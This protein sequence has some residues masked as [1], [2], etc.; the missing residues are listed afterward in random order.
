MKRVVAILFVCLAL[1]SCARPTP[2]KASCSSL[3]IQISS[4]PGVPEAALNSFQKRL[5]LLF[6]DVAKIQPGSACHLSVAI[7]TAA[8]GVLVS[9]PDPLHFNLPRE[10]AGRALL[11]AQLKRGDETLWSSSTEMVFAVD[12]PEVRTAMLLRTF[13]ETVDFAGAINPFE[14]ANADAVYAN[15]CT[16]ADPHL[17]PTALATRVRVLR[18]VDLSTGFG[19]PCRECWSLLSIGGVD[20]ILFDPLGSEEKDFE[21]AF[22]AAYRPRYLS[23]L[24]AHLNLADPLTGEPVAL[25]MIGLD[26]DRVPVLRAEP[27]AG[28]EPTPS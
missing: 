19:G 26:K 28:I 24:Q 7:T 16:Q 1:A 15:L 20:K 3:D 13:F 11:A 21:A 2:A 6:F 9:E 25:S 27:A 8:P 22:G 5:K 23:A 17:V 14:V 4:D 12:T 18:Y 10:G